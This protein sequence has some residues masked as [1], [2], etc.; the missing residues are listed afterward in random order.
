MECIC[1]YKNLICKMK[2]KIQKA[3]KLINI[4]KYE[5]YSMYVEVK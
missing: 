2:V 5:K 3:G 1:Q 4:R